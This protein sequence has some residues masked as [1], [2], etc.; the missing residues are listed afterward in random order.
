MRIP[1]VKV[2]SAKIQF[3]ELSGSVTVGEESAKLLSKKLGREVKPGETFDLG[4]LAV[5]HQNSIKRFLSNFKLFFKKNI[6]N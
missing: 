3:A 1:A 4:V 5:Y 6:F 2:A